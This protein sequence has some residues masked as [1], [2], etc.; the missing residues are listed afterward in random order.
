MTAP[1]QYRILVTGASGFVGCHVLPILTALGHQVIAVGN[2]REIK[3]TDEVIWRRADLLDESQ[4]RVV[5]REA[6]ANVLIHLAW[7]A[8]PGKYWTALENLDWVRATLVLLDEFVKQG[9][10]R[11]VCAGTCAEYDWGHGY[12]TEDITPLAPRT[13][14]GTCKNSARQLAQSYCD[15]SGLELAWGRIFFP[16]GSGEDEARLIPSIISSLVDGATVRCSHGQQYR[17]FIH[18]EDVANAFAHLVCG[19][20]AT[21]TFNICSGQPIR[22]AEIVNRCVE[23]VRP[24]VIPAFGTVP[25]PS[26]DPPLL[27]GN[28]ARLVSTGWQPEISLENGIMAYVA[29]MLSS[30]DLHT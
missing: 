2:R 9:G 7:Y 16:Y 26:D 25:V 17:D 3:G 15:A 18:V 8:T 29:Q 23:L 21:G 6:E 20:G 14:Y 12:C 13:I 22:I 10:K 24:G 11:A 4:C 19:T 27:V 5:V 1:S 28:N 30:A